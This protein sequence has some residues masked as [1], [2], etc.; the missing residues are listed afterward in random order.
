MKKTIYLSLVLAATAVLIYW[1]P[2]DD[3]RL[4]VTQDEAAPALSTQG[5]TQS[6]SKQKQSSQSS[7]KNDWSAS[8]FELADGTDV[9]LTP[10][11]NSVTAAQS[12]LALPEP[13]IITPEEAA[14]RKKLHDLGY[15][16]PP[17][18]Y[19][20]NLKTLKQMAKKGDAYAMVHLGEKYYFELNG[21][22]QHPEY[23]SNV[24]YNR[25]A[26]Q[27]FQ[28]ALA[29]GNVRSAGIIAELYFQEKNSL[30]AYAWHLVSGRLGDDISAEWFSRTDMALQASLELK[31]A[32]E[33]RAAEILEEMKRRKKQA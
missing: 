24:D 29:A 12:M 17:E 22:T 13:E 28:D 16:V 5:N 27:S 11:A 23:E 21:Q 1:L 10:Q 25:A 33:R 14:R 7:A 2:S 3:Q 6:M 32:A 26:K 8:P 9:Q 20:K 31:Q 18:Y 19:E 15:M 4:G 30:E